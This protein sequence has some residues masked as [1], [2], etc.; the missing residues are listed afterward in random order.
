MKQ[1]EIAYFNRGGYLVQRIVKSRAKL[2]FLRLIK[3]LVWVY[4]HPR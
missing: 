1:Y 4:P 3:N 2:E